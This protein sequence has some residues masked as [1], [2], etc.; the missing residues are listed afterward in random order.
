MS[1]NNEIPVMSPYILYTR[2]QWYQAGS[3]RSKF[4]VFY[5]YFYYLRFNQINIE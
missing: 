4:Y 3:A 2:L 1:T 5:V